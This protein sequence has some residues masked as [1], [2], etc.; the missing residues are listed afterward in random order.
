MTSNSF[1]KKILIVLWI[2]FISSSVIIFFVGGK[3]FFFKQTDS[4]SVVKA[5]ND[6]GEMTTGKDI[7][8]SF[9]A[10]FSEINGLDI[11]GGDYDRDIGGKMTITLLNQEN[12]K[13][14]ER[15]YDMAAFSGEGKFEIDFDEAINVTNGDIITLRIYVADGSFN[16]VPTIYYGSE[17]S[18]SRGQLKLELDDFE[19]IVV[20]GETL[21]GK[22]CFCVYGSEPIAFGNYYWFFIIAV[23]IAFSFFTIRQF[24]CLKKSKQTWFLK[25]LSAVEKYRYLISQ[26]VS[27][28]FKRK[29][30]RSVLGVIWSLLNPML[31]MVVQYVVFS[32]IFKSEIENFAVYLLSGIVC[33]NFF[34]EVTNMS[35]TSI[36]ENSSLITKVYIPKF[37]YPISRAFSSCINFFLSLIPL[38]IVLA[39]TQ[40]H[41][42]YAVVLV[43]FVMICL[44]MLSLGV[45]MALSASMV[46]FRDTQFLWN[47]F[48]MI[49]MYL[50][51][52]FYP[53]SII[54]GWMGT[55]FKF[56]PLYHII[57]FFRIILLEGISPE[58]KAYLMCILTSIIP[59]IIGSIIFNRTKDKFVLYI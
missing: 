8:Q 53:E 20:D 51:P 7:F 18:V 58:P 54:T 22:M 52:I 44:F 24:S 23:L 31:I 47:V 55:I 36:I 59:L 57:R 41:I 40:T 25:L 42:T 29:Y 10:N 56:N 6:V 9:K 26:L 12:E 19:K 33:Y 17:V 28:D 46:F 2:I 14:Y 39:I 38:V 49:W 50:T 34:S 3:Q 4:G 27:R 16:S 1:V 48:N 37:I 11:F 15:D 43:P 21:E 13:L 30:K 32:T 35:L 5:S 45:G